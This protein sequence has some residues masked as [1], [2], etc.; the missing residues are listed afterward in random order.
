[1]SVQDSIKRAVGMAMSVVIGRLAFREPVRAAKLVAITLM[2][3][4][5]LLV[6]TPWER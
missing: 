2:G 4:G 5:M 6:L 1:V 3:A